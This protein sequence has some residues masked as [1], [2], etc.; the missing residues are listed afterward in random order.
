MAI[1]YFIHR[2][3]LNGIYARVFAGHAWIYLIIA[4]TWACVK[5]SLQHSI[6]PVKYGFGVFCFVWLWYQFL[7]DLCYLYVSI[8]FMV[9]SL[10][11][12]QWYD[13]PS[14]N[15]QDVRKIVQSH[16]SHNAPFPYP[17][18][19]HSEQKCSHFC[20]EWCIV[21]YGIGALWDLWIW[22][23]DYYL[24][25]TKHKKVQIMCVF[26]GIYFIWMGMFCY[27]PTT[28]N[29]YYLFFSCLKNDSIQNVVYWHVPWIHG[30][31]MVC[32]N[33]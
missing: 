19:H 26:H 10:A 4:I 16:K 5:L 12:G 8:F 7:A 27:I 3:I 11:Q 18:M 21:G 32:K 29:I 28:G 33:G 15:L 25:I 13:C 14:V 23:I 1:D 6:Y 9:A 20:S 31:K 24:T 30:I 22:S 17:T 2:T